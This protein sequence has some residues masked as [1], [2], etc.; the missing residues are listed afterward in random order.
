MATV[1]LGARVQF[2]EK[3]LMVLR[4]PETS[5]NV[6]VISSGCSGAAVR[7]VHS[8]DNTHINFPGTWLW[9][10]VRFNGPIGQFGIHCWWVAVRVHLLG[11]ADA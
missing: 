5:T 8:C 10:R 7:S 2:A 3:I 4:N 1:D 6:S 11:I 9:T